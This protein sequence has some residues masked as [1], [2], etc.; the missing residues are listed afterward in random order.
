MQLVIEEE[1]E[2]LVGPRHQQDEQ[3]RGYRWGNEAAI[4]WWVDRRRRSN[5]SACAAKMVVSYRPEL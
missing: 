3:R 2:R 5:G 1:A 4:V